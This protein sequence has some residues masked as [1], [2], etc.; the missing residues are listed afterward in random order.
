MGLL[1][2]EVP[3]TGSGGAAHGQYG[4]GRLRLREGQSS[5]RV[6]AWRPGLACA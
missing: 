1:V 2:V 6:K 4:L 5:S 3:R